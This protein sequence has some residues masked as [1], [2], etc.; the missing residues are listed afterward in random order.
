MGVVSMTFFFSY[1]SF[2]CQLGYSLCVV[3]N[4]GSHQE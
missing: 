1:F 4:F 3:S 2:S